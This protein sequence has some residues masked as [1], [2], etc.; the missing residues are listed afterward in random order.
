MRNYQPLALS[1]S[2]LRCN[3]FVSKRPLQALFQRCDYFNYCF[4]HHLW[5]H[6]TV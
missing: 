6:F 5:H 3:M 2:H 1:P 4:F